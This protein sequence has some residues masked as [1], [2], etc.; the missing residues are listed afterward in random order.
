ML[1]S[2]IQ[3]TGI[4]GFE[5]RLR[6]GVFPGAAD[7]IVVTALSFGSIQYSLRVWVGP[8]VGVV[9]IWTTLRFA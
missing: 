4:V 6:K 2:V 9:V 8:G 3:A 1:G 7:T 5:G